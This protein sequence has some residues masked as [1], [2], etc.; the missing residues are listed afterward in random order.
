MRLALFSPL[1]PAFSRW[2]AASST[3]QKSG[4][5][6]TRRIYRPGPWVRWRTRQ[7]LAQLD[8]RQLADIGLTPAQ[9]RHEIHQPFWR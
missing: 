6:D 5:Q 3:T 7:Q 9:A 4:I 8:A 1:F 2:R